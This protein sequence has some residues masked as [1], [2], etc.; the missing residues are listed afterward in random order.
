M[1]SHISH[2]SYHS[3]KETDWNIHDEQC[4]KHKTHILH[5]IDHLSMWGFM[6]METCHNIGIIIVFGMQQ[7]KLEFEK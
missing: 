5:S 6:N 3:W 7:K 1:T 4:R 2:I